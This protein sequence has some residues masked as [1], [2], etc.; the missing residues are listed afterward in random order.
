M[1]EL[2]KSYEKVYKDG[3]NHRKQYFSLMSEWSDCSDGSMG[4][5]LKSATQK[6]KKIE[7]ERDIYKEKAEKLVYIL[8]EKD[9]KL[10]LLQSDRKS[11]V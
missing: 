7:G 10:R 4:L 5:T 3:E 2:K 9:K 11:V 1:N 8:K 6:L